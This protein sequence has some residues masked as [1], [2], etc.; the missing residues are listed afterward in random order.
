MHL[1]NN[2]HVQK[3][4]KV[5]TNIVT[6]LFSLFSKLKVR[7]LCWPTTINI[8]EWE[9]KLAKKYYLHGDAKFDR[10]SGSISFPEDFFLG[11]FFLI[12]PSIFG[13]LA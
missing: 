1:L 9:C 6:K 12:S 4:F 2:L 10:S 11:F 7:V 13:A 5:L 8:S 3:D